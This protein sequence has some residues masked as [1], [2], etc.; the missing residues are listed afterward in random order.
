MDTCNDGAV[1][2]PR[3]GQTPHHNVRVDLEL[4]NAAVAK[5]RREGRSLTAVL[6]AYLKRYVASP[7]RKRSGDDE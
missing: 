4:W 1:P 3:T 2:R 6:V 7:D 5:A